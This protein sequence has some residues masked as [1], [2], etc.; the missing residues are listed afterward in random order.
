VAVAQAIHGVHHILLG[1][2]QGRVNIIV[3]PWEQ[4]GKGVGAARDGLSVKGW[5]WARMP[6]EGS[7]KSIQLRH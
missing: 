5:H 4:Q 2:A 3:I 6:I 1:R 7:N